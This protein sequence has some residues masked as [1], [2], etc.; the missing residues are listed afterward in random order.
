MEKKVVLN[1]YS[2]ILNVAGFTFIDDVKCRKQLDG[3]PTRCVLEGWDQSC[4][5]CVLGIV[6]KIVTCD[7]TFVHPVIREFMYMLIKDI[8]L[9][10]FILI[11]DN[12]YYSL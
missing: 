6:N 7:V 8:T 2:K 10:Y 9:F 4:E 12:I 3:T 11:S 5:C 1:I